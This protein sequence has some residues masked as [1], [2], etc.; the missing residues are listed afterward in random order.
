[1]E[2]VI[3]FDFDNTLYNGNVW[4]DWDNYMTKFL[5]TYFASEKAKNDF[6]NKYVN[7]EYLDDRYICEGLI[8]E[9]GTSQ[10]LIDY[11]IENP[12]DYNGENVTFIDNEYLKQLSKKHH[13]YIVSNTPSNTIRIALKKYGI[14]DKYFK[15][16]FFNA[17]T[18]LQVSKKDWYEKIMQLENVENS[19]VIVIGDSYL[20]DIKP[21][22]QL[23]T[24]YLQVSSLKDIYNHNFEE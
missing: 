5:D 8:K 6:I 22:Q 24:K 2:K 7:A 20:S 3:I 13:L 9:S 14:D 4:N 1:M 12:Y 10:P 23:G 18:N 16:I 19:D 15:D 21:A 11:L 17:K